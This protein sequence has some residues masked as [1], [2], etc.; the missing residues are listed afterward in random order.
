MR[1]NAAHNSSTSNELL[2]CVL[3][4]PDKSV[5]DK[6]V[7]R[8][9]NQNLSLTDP[10]WVDSQ[11]LKTIYDILQAN[12]ALNSTMLIQLLKAKMPLTQMELIELCE[13]Y[14]SNVRDVIKTGYELTHPLLKQILKPKHTPSSAV[15]R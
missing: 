4:D 13:L 11:T 3:K 7:T 8:L 5:V 15:C 10:S 14:D 9:Q 12:N 1:W 2:W 6:A